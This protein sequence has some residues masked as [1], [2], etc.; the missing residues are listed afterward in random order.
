[1]FVDQPLSL[2]LIVAP[3]KF[4]GTPIA[5]S[6]ALNADVNACVLVAPADAVVA[7]N[8]VTPS[9][10]VY[11]AT[12]ITVNDIDTPHEAVITLLAFPAHGA[13][14]SNI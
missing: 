9:V 13:T 12:I 1:M 10:V 4:F 3:E 7:L 14:T 5:K 11:R 6:P 2:L 8:V